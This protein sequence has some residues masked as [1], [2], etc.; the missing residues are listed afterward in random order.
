MNKEPTI[1][2]IDF[3]Q[4]KKEDPTEYDE[5]T[6]TI[7]VRSTYDIENDPEGWLVH[8]RIHAYLASIK[9]EDNYNPPLIEYPFNNVERH[10]YTWQFVYLLETSRV[11]SIDNIEFFM[12]WKFERYGDEW[13]NDY[14]N[15]A[16][17]KVRND[18]PDMP[19]N[20]IH[21]GG[22]FESCAEQ[23][24]EEI[25]REIVD[26]AKRKNSLKSFST[27]EENS[28]ASVKQND[29]SGKGCIVV[30]VLIVILT[31]SLAVYCT[32]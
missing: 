30:I 3:T 21:G 11:K 29:S 17:A 16:L 4:W 12:P 6:D 27:V 20:I 5:S 8:E 31:I 25:F 7:F 22:R 2:T 32:L 9:F 28:Q 13:A 19:P 15:K 18:D 1:K 10:A 23:Q 24:L 26:D 14:F